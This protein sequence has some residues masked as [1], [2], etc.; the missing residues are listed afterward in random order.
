[1]KT[2]KEILVDERIQNGYSLDFGS[3]INSSI[4][5]F[6]IIWGPAGLAVLIL[7]LI[8]SVLGLG[9]FGVFYGF[10]DLTEELTNFNP[11]S[12]SIFESLVF[13][14]ITSLTSGFSYLFTAG[15][16]EMAHRADVGLDFSLETAFHHF[17]S[18]FT[19]DLFV[20]GLVIGLV[21]ALISLVINFMHIPFVDS[22][23]SI[24]IGVLTIF[25]IPLIVYSELPF[26]KAIS[27]SIQLAS[28]NIPLIFA[29]IV[30]A[31]ILA[32]L[33][34][35]ALCIGVLFTISFVYIVN[36]AIYNSILPTNKENDILDEIGSSNE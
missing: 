33:G 31:T 15:I 27:S 19:K 13:A 2:K 30:V 6:K 20:A 23:L 5:L 35:F 18:R 28:K 32:M 24:L 11:K 10:S 26:E 3:I 34:F 7:G 4:E 16:I 17:K 25:V 12:F 21:S 22:I 1:M 29:L 9:V 8:M 14:L 36:Y